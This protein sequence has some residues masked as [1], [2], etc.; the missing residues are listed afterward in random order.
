ML[1]GIEPDEGQNML[2]ALPVNLYAESISLLDSL[3]RVTSEDIYSV[4]MVPPFDRSPYDGYAFRGE[5]TADAESEKPVILSITEEIPAGQV[6][7]KEI[8]PGLAAKILTGAPMPAGANTTIKYEDTEFTDSEVKIFAP[9]KPGTNIINVG[10]K[11]GIGELIACAGTIITAPIMGLLAEQGMTKVNVVKKPL[12]TVINTGT[13]LVE[14]GNPLSPAQ[15]YNCNFYTISSYLRNIGAIPLNGGIVPDNPD[16]TADRLQTALDN[17]DMVITTGG[18]C[19]SDYDWTVKASALLGADILFWKIA[20]KPG[21]AITAAVLNG[22]LILGLSGNPEAAVV[23]LLR[24]ALPYIRKLC[25]ISDTFLP[26]IETVLREPIKRKNTMLRLLRG[27]LE[28][29]SG[30]AYFVQDEGKRNL[31]PSPLVNFDLLGELSP[32]SPPLE[33]GAKIKSYLINI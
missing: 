4:Q 26:A 29:V 22:K 11:I 1:I 27:K 21:G 30:I 25:G 13:E 17:S 19:G 23:G 2:L 28:I 12:I 8:K 10:D 14:L 32:G 6:S 16:M 33:A 24:I 20:M 9:V 5:D 15:I 3:G 18:V 31:L 7:L